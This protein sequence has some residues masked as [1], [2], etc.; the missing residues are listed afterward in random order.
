MSNLLINEPPLQV[1]PSL[2][3]A[4]GLNEAIALQQLHYWL[5]HSKKEHDGKMWIYKT[6]A[7]WRSQ[8]FPFWSERTIQ[9]TFLNL[10]K[11]GLVLAEKLSDNK[12][13][14]VN[15][16]TVNYENLAK[17]ETK[18][19]SNQVK[20]HSAKLAPS[21]TTDWHYPSCQNGTIQDAKMA[22][23]LR[24][25][26]EIKKETNSDTLNVSFDDFW[27]L[28]DKK[29]GD[30]E[31]IKTKWTK[32]KDSDREAIMKHLPLYKKSQPNKKY[33]K[34]PETYLNQ[35]SWNDEIIFDDGQQPVSHGYTEQVADPVFDKVVL[36][37][38]PKVLAMIAAK[39]K[40]GS[41]GTA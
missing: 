32:L 2:A 40:G 38:D 22:P 13:N 18:T 41:H 30:K 6:Y 23:S 3:A 8:D 19:R 26:K 24:D 33:R 36:K 7:D 16:Y 4:I 14:K 39:R 37:T 11:A 9:R 28:Y 34:N 1:L 17:L 15:F 29:V 27:N 12:H 31:K 35:K 25:N 5:A 20:S 10:E 21:N